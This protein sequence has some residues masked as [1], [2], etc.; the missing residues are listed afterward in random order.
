M[1]R[2]FTVT[3]TNTSEKLESIVKLLT[4]ID[5]VDYWRTYGRLEASISFDGREVSYLS[6]ENLAQSSI[7]Q[8][9]IIVHGK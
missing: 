5:E 9:E 6:D 8:N 4:N 1:P 7:L 3:V 2:T